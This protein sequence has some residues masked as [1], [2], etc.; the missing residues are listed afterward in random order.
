MEGVHKGIRWRATQEI[1]WLMEQG[2]CRW[3]CTFGARMQWH[4]MSVRGR[5]G[6]EPRA[7]WGECNVWWMGEQL[8]C[9]QALWFFGY[10]RA[11]SSWK[12]WGA[13]IATEGHAGGNGH[14]QLRRTRVGRTWV[15]RNCTRR[16]EETLWSSSAAHSAAAAAALA[17][18]QGHT[19]NAY[20]LIHQFW[21][22]A[23][24]ASVQTL[25]SRLRVGLPYLCML[26]IPYHSLFPLSPNSAAYEKS[27][28]G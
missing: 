4:P 28:S 24:N 20:L 18:Q 23:L 19:T 2:L 9:A 13:E 3:R 21:P 12:A 27:V 6:S 25:W 26:W 16:T 10:L 5:P 22:T 15:R 14:W 1:G 8:W 17:A 7:R 11:R